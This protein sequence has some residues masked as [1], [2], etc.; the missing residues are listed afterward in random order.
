[1]NDNVITLPDGTR[2]CDQF[3]LLENYLVKYGLDAAESGDEFDAALADWHAVND[4]QE[5][6]GSLFPADAPT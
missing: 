4:A 1:M 5:V 6:T 3:T 2:H